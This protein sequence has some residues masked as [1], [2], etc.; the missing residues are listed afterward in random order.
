VFLFS[1]QGNFTNHVHFLRGVKEG[2]VL[3]I[4]SALHGNEIN[5]IPLIHRL[6]ED[7]DINSILGTIVAIPVANPTGY[8]LKQKNFN[9]GADLNT[10]FPGVQNGNCS[11]Q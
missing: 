6:F 2:P 5:G 9:D 4:V 11:Q 3:G 8:Q 7:L 10:K 1:L